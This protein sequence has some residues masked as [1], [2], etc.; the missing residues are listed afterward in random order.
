M[1]HTQENLKH[2]SKKGKH[3][4]NVK[5]HF[6]ENLDSDIPASLGENVTMMKLKKS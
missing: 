1:T 2:I 5:L 4:L 6:K 3:T